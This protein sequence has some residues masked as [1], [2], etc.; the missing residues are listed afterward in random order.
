MLYTELWLSY[1]FIVASVQCY[2]ATVAET[3][4][5]WVVDLKWLDFFVLYYHSPCVSF[6]IPLPSFTLFPSPKVSLAIGT[7]PQS[8]RDFEVA[9]EANAA[10]VFATGSAEARSTLGPLCHLAPSCP[11][12]KHLGKHRSI[13]KHHLKHSNHSIFDMIWRSLDALNRN[14]WQI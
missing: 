2:S 6:T 3:G 10:K 11:I 14:L 9:A 7:L 8:P 12:G 5:D 1:A 13:M 4:R